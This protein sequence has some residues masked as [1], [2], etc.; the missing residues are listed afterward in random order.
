MAKPGHK[1][2]AAPRPWPVL[3]GDAR[4]DSAVWH[5]S[6]VLRDISKSQASDRKKP[7]TETPTESAL[8]GHVHSRSVSSTGTQ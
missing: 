2:D 1:P 7:P 8:T 6:V 5:L 3:T 4:T